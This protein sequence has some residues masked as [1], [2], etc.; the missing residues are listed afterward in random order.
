MKFTLDA[1]QKAHKKVKS[2][3]DFPAY[4]KAI[5]QLGV[6]RY[7]F[8]VADGHTVFYDGGGYM[9]P[10]EPSYSLYTIAETATADRFKEALLLHQ[11]GA[12]DFPAFCSDCARWGV[13]KWTVCL[14]DNTCTYFDMKDTVILTEHI[15][16]G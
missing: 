6:S 5:K 2:G 13:E 3:A 7:T 11:Q 1:L 8:Y 9:L 15:P 12:T 4:C 16:A 10:T 14:E